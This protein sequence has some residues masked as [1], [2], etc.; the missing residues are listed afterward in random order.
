MV[1][2]KVSKLFYLSIE[3]DC[4]VTVSK[5]RMTQKSILAYAVVQSSSTYVLHFVLHIC[6]TGIDS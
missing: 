2:A 4:F 5:P 6:L 3:M 1:F